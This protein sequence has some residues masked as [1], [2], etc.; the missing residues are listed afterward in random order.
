MEER[1]TERRAIGHCEVWD[2]WVGEGER[3]D[4]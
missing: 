4:G 1:G 2:V 3:L